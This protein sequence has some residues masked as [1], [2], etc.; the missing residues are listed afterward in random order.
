VSVSITTLDDDLQRRMEPRASRPELRLDAISRLAAAGVPVGVMVGPVLPGL[1]DHEIPKILTRAA[2][3]GARFASYTLLRLPHGVADLFSDWLEAHYPDRRKKVLDRI[4]DLRAGKLNDPRFGS[5]HRGVGAFAAQIAQLFELGR[6][7]AGL[8]DAG[9]TLSAR[10]FR[11]PHSL[12]S[13]GQ[14]GP[15]LERRGTARRTTPPQ[16]RA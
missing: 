16:P 7:R 3:A 5:R 15:R 2:R 11:R 6:R 10:A 9:P 12:F 14:L 8:S 13:E 1:T 4:R